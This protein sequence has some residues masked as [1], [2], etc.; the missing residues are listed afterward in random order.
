MSANFAWNWP[1]RFIPTPVGNTPVSAGSSPRLFTLGGPYQ[2]ENAGSSPRLWGTPKLHA[3]A[4]SRTHTG[5]SPRLWGTRW[6]MTFPIP[7]RFI[8]TP[9]GNTNEF[10]RL[11]LVNLMRRFIPTPV[12]NTVA[13][14]NNP[15]SPRFIPTPVGNTHCRRHLQFSE[16]P[17]HPHACGEHEV[18]GNIF[19]RRFIPTPVGNTTYYLC[20]K[21]AFLD[22]FIPTPVGNTSMAHLRRECRRFIPTPVGNTQTLLRVSYHR[23]ITVH[24]HACGEHRFNIFIGPYPQPVHPHA[25]GEHSSMSGRR[26]K[27]PVHPHACGEH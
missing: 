6:P 21:I 24:P 18:K 1:A 11:A 2:A 16:V 13:G 19:M 10:M 12:G 26:V 8:P 15:E 25:C 5:S 20:I 17:V 4:R 22:R 23:K 7:I 3:I 27:R 14:V 9:V